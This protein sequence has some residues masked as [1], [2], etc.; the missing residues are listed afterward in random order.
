MDNDELMDLLARCTL[1]DQ[2]ALERLY[3]KTAAYLNGVAYRILGSSDASNDVLQ[4]AFVQIW[5]NAAS[6]Q[7]GR[8]VGYRFGF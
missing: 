6:Y 8:R 7:S 2:K 4:E 5:E 1:R 3:Q